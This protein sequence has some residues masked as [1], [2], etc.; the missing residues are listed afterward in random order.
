MNLDVPRVW[1]VDLNAGQIKDLL[2]AQ[3]K[4][5]VLQFIGGRI[6]PVVLKGGGG[7]KAIV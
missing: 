4:L 6:P 2:A 1:A 5:A 3:R 7:E